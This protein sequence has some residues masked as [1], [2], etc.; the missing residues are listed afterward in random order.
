MLEDVRIDGAVAV[1]HSPTSLTNDTDNQSTSQFVGPSPSVVDAEINED[2]E[3]V[4]T[5]MRIDKG[6]TKMSEEEYAEM[7]RDSSGPAQKSRVVLDVSQEL[8]PGII[9]KEELEY[10]LMVFG[11]QQSASSP[12]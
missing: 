8:P 6:K 5:S 1:P 2:S 7:M 4:E 12:K 11:R 3:G 9:S 10:N